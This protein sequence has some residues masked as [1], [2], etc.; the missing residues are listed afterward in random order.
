MR[1]IIG[2]G[3]T[4]LDIIFE[5][6]QP[7]AAKPG[8]STFNAL[9]SLGRA[10]NRSIFMSETGNDKVGDIVVHFLEQNNVD[11]S[12]VTRYSDGKSA[13]SLAFLNAQKDAEYSFYK[14]YPK[15]RIDTSLPEINEDDIIL[16]G[17]FF[18][19][20]PSL[21]PVILALLEEANK[22]GAII[23]YDPNF[24]SSH[25]EQRAELIPTLLENFSA[26]SIVRG[27]DEDFKNILQTNT[28]IETW[29]VMQQHCTTL[30]YTCNENGIEVSTPTVHKHYA[31]PR[32]KPLST[33]G[34]GDNFNAGF[35]YAL[36][37]QNIRKKDLEHLS[38]AQ[39]DKLIESAI[40]FSQDVCL[41]YEN[42]I[43]PEF[44]KTLK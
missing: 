15:Q 31:V 11:S 19:L 36:L 13:L 40:G 20:N 24:R 35:I 5:S 29:N 10:G 8:G 4:V 26:A 43:S 7:V 25:L 9:I 37:K 42:Y 17:S 18:A 44:V 14:D 21:R 12:Y 2:I 34:A 1:K 28:M 39:W 33:I 41:S 38:E 32:I 16:F 3:E 30:I 22:K 27:S 6:D 23:Y